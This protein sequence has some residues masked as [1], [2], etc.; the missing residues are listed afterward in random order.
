ME[1]K[2]HRKKNGKPLEKPHPPGVT[3]L[4][5]GICYFSLLHPFIINRDIHREVF[6]FKENDSGGTT[7]E[8]LRYSELSGRYQSR[9]REC[10]Q[11]QRFGFI[12]LCVLLVLAFLFSFKV[13]SFLMAAVVLFTGYE[14]LDRRVRYLWLKREY[15]RKRPDA[16]T[17]PPVGREAD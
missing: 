14:Y 15:Y 11:R 9:I 17:E 2:I 16:Q 7:L 5:T 3:A 12:I 10:E 6:V 1:E 13:F 8:R 4:D